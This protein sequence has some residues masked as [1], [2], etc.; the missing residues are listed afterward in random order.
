[1]KRYHESSKKT[2]DE[3]GTVAECQMRK[4]VQGILHLYLSNPATEIL[5][6]LDSLLVTA[7]SIAGYIVVSMLQLRSR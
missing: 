3:L 4:A 6:H 5:T 2:V 7:K 1:M